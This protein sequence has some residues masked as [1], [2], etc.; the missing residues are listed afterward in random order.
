MG[1]VLVHIHYALY[2]LGKTEDLTDKLR[3]ILA[4]M[5]Y[6]Y[7]VR[8]WDSLGVPFRSHFYV[9]EKHPITDDVFHERE[10]DGHVLKVSSPWS[11]QLSTQ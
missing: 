4:Q 6:T 9:P 7:R 1:E 11:N 2:L 3:S 10:D 5:E 8:Y